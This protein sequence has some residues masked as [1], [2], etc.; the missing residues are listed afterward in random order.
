MI[1]LEW[2]VIDYYDSRYESP[3]A[4]ILNKETGEKTTLSTATAESNAPGSNAV[5]INTP[6]TM[7]GQ[8]ETMDIYLE[9]SLKAPRTTLASLLTGT[10][11]IPT[12]NIIS[13][14]NHIEIR[15]NYP[16][17]STATANIVKNSKKLFHFSSLF[18]SA[19]SE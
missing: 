7:L 18:Q 19:N 4:Y 10:E 16:R 3:K 9:L 5:I 14:E 6:S 12:Y 17:Q 15:K 13:R 11:K 2:K 1:V 8:S